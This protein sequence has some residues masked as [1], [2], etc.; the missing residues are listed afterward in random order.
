MIDVR[1]KAR[2]G[3]NLFQYCFGRILAEGLGFE[4]RAAPIDGFPNTSQHVAGARHQSPEVV[5]TGQ[6]VDVDAILRDRHPRKIVLDGWF[7]R[8]EYYRPHRDRIRRWLTFAP[9]VRATTAATT[10]LHI[11]RTDYVQL[12]WALP[13]SFYEAALQH[14]PAGGD[15]WILTD[16][17]GDPFF[18][19]FQRWQPKFAKG[20]PLEDLRLMAGAR[21]IVM[22]QSTFSWWPTF[23]GDPQIVVCPDPSFGAWAPG[24]DA[25]DTR[26]IER[27]RFVCLPCASPDEPTPAEA[28][29]QARRLF[30]RRLILAMNRRLGTTLAVPPH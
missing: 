1:Y 27:D 15:L 8:Y 20:T 24:G 10:V 4:L 2:L 3:N 16:D 13:F 30:R 18:H 7:Q 28:R 26:L 5:L 9:A 14:A 6:L 12:G 19:R 29:Y 17:P 22:S 23:L 11:R 25:A 21:C